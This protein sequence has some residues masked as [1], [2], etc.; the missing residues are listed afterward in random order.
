[1]DRKGKMAIRRMKT[2]SRKTREDREN[3]KV[4]EWAML[5]VVGKIIMKRIPRNQSGSKLQSEMF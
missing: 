5:K 1:M 4:V 3:V 2:R